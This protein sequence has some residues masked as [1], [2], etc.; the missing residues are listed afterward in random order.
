MRSEPIPSLVS[1]LPVHHKT[2]MTDFKIDYQVG[3][4]NKGQESVYRVYIPSAHKGWAIMADKEDAASA[5]VEALQRDIFVCDLRLR[6]HY[7]SPAAIR[8]C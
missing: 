5:R 3:R 1:H 8:Q 6:K 2:L 4:D 7:F